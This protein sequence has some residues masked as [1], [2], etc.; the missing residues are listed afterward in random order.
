MVS[1]RSRKR[2]QIGGADEDTYAEADVN[3]AVKEDEGAGACDD[4]S[5]RR[6]DATKEAAETFRRLQCTGHRSACPDPVQDVHV[7]AAT[8]RQPGRG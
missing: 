5:C 8:T 4:S 6:L 7:P 2:K 3:S 1:T